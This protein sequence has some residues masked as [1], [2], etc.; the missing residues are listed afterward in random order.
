MPSGRGRRTR[1]DSGGALPGDARK[2][3]RERQR[4]DARRTRAGIAVFVVAGTVVFGLLLGLAATASFID[5]LP[6]LSK[7]GPI[8][9]GKNSS[10]YVR[11]CTKKPCSDVPLGV[12]ARAEN[13]VSV[14]WRDIAPTMRSATVAIEDRRYWE[15]GALD[16]HGIARA[17]LNNVRAGSITQ[18]GS[19][20][21]QQLAKNLYLQREARSRSISRKIDEAWIAVQLEDKY[22]KAEIL[23]AY[24]NTVFY[25][26]NAY[27][28][29]A[30]A[31]TFFDK[32]AKRLTLPQSALLAGLPQAPTDYN[33]FLHPAAARDRRNE[34]LQ[35]MRSLRWISADAYAQARNASLGLKRGTYGTAV[36]SPFVFEQVRQ[37]LGAKLPSKLAARGG[38]RVYSTVDQ[39][40]QFA[41]RRAIK[42]VLKS[43]GDPQAALVAINVHNGNVLALGTSDYF[44]A[45]NQ[46]NLATVGH[47]SPGSTFKLF[48]LVDALRRGA[49]PTKVFYPSG[50]VSFPENDPVCPQAGG[51]SP[52]NAESGFGGYMSLETA[53]IHSVNVVYS[54]LMHDLGPAGVAATAHLLGIRS[55][56]PLH[57]SMVLGADDVTP[58][59]LT[60]AYATIASGGIY[61]T[62]RVIRRV[63]NA[64]GHLVADNAFKVHSKRVVSEG[65]AYETTSIL[66]QV[67]TEGT[68]T[69][70]RLDD[71]RPEAGKTGTAENYGNAWFCGYTPDIASCVWVGYRGSNKPLVG[72]EGVGAV[73]GGTLPAAI[74]KDFMTTAT[75]RLP[76]HD[77]PEP[78][79]PMVFHE[80][81]ATTSFGYN[82]KAPPAPPATP[83]HKPKKAKPNPPPTPDPSVPVQI[84]PQNG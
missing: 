82:P 63:E 16:W 26:Q 55:K 36:S 50:Y 74:W 2:R 42:D 68:G 4:R 65:I 43:P 79:K 47:R 57:C 17:A 78:K 53:T 31:H 84:A 30:A 29:E 10:V 8:E 33:P 64:K 56:L 18:G 15:H 37:E 19:T 66:K 51:W 6:K 75:R 11:N 70:A 39:R 20:L 34:V 83:A 12:I 60:S 23:T 46:F 24:L 54:Q 13:R 22:T 77:W 59:E 67:I 14:R 35:A 58:L 25:G 41:A 9:L 61:H 21:T 52:S 1:L 62:P 5:H 7:L 71:G 45:T 44:S 81:K 73:F 40:L 69:H 3:R 48:A 38:Y 28:V 80:F 49:D 72:I 27:G 76:P 32:P